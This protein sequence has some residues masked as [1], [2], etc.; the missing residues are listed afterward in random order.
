MDRLEK[1]WDKGKKF[2]GTE[3]PIL[4]GGMTWISDY[5]L[6]KAISD[7]G[8]F[9]V[10]AAG[11]MPLDMFETE[12]DKCV[13]NIKK[14]FAVNLITIAPNYRDHYEILRKKDVPFVIFA[15]SFPTRDD[16]V[17]MKEAGK[18]TISFAST[19]SIASRQIRW[20]IDALI[21]EGSEAGGHIGHVSL[22]ILLQ[23][24]LMKFRDFPIFVAGGIATGEMMAHLFLMGAYGVQ[25]GTRFVVSEECSA[26]VDFK[27]AF[28]RAKA[29]QAVSTPQYD[30][31]LPI[32]SVRGIKNVA[33]DK[34]G[35]LQ[36]DL[37]EK[38]RSGD[39]SR[40]KAQFEVENYW[41]GALRNGVVDGDVTMGSLMAGQ[42]VGLVNKIQPISEIMDELVTS[43]RDEI[44]RT[45]DLLK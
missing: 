7:N 5:N 11:N 37:L 44:N 9:P 35:E 28:I 24:V 23:Q 10:L 22:V 13:A 40:E 30:P 34:F 12:V 25:F 6:V 38:M 15:G 41:V 14:P 1:L 36:L 27:K 45:Y 32:V 39:L 4:C 33:M 19:E 3:Y 26:H 43:C 21:L 31:K 8:G 17:G 20:G 16:V 29:R 42:S 18:K 2:L